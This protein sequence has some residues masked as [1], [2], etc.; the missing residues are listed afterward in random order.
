[1]SVRTVFRSVD[2]G[3]FAVYCVS[4]TWSEKQQQLH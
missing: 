4:S 2:F 1:M 3:L